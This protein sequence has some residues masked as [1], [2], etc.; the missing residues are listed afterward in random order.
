MAD[1]SSSPDTERLLAIVDARM[2]SLA[3]AIR[4]RDWQD[5]EFQFDRALSALRKAQAGGAPRN[6]DGSRG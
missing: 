6:P 2:G 3:Q 5:V 4:G 1:A